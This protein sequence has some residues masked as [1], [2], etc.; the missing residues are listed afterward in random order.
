[1][2]NELE[3]YKSK[4]ERY[5]RALRQIVDVKYRSYDA[6]LSAA[7]YALSEQ[8][9]IEMEDAARAQVYPGKPPSEFTP[10]S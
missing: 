10:L 5:E 9:R 8:D 4:S 1:M 3:Y 6:M 2:N 7:R